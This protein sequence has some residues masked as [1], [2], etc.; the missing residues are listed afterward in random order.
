MIGNG[1]FCATFRGFSREIMGVLDMPTTGQTDLPFL[2][3]PLSHLPC[4]L[5]EV[6]FPLPWMLFVG[7]LRT[8]AMICTGTNDDNS[9]KTISK[10]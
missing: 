7:T 1:I 4:P 5:S 2:E 8:N 10:N 6:K 9:I 3:I